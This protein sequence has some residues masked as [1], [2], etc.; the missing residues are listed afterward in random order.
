MEDKSMVDEGAPRDQADV[1]YHLDDEGNWAEVLR[2]PVSG[3]SRPALFLDR[4]GVIVEEIGYLHRAAD[5][6]IIPGAATVIAE[7]NRRRIP[8]VMV[9]NQ[10]GIARGYYSWDAFVEVQTAITAALAASGACLDGIFACPHH[11]QGRSPYLHPN[12]P[13]RKPNPGMLLSAAWLMQLDLARSWI[14]GDNLIDIL[15]GKAGGLVGS[16]LVKTG[17]G[18]CHTDAVQRLADDRFIVHIAD[19]LADAPSVLPIFR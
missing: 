13:S 15:A 7:A 16:M 12:H 4:D 11:Q 17:H 6:R 19:S 2:R 8:V 10:A 5:T 18:A 1:V 14:I 9:T 3:N